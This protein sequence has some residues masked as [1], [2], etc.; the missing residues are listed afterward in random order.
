MFQ[1]ENSRQIFN[2]NAFDQTHAFY[3]HY[4]GI[5]IV[6]ARFMSFLRT[7][8]PFVPAWRA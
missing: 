8:A 7:F 5:T 1:W 2:K 3:E 6:A 4:G